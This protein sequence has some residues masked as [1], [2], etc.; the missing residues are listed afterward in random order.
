ML[1]NTNISK[2][3]PPTSRLTPNFNLKKKAKQMKEAGKIKTE[4]RKQASNA[5]GCN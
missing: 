1:H 3:F 2:L 5:D 4:G